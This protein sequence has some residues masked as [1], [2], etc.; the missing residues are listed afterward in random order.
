MIPDISVI[1]PVYNVERYLPDCLDSVLGQEGCTLEV[2]LIDDGSTDRSGLICDQYAAK[3]SRIKVIHQKNAGAAAAKNVGLR[4][5]TGEC[6]SFV[7]SDDFLEPGAYSY[8]LAQLCEYDADMIQCAFRN[9]FPNRSEDIIVLPEFTHFEA[10]EYLPR[11][12][13][14][15]TCGLL[16]DKLYRRAL[17]DGISFEEGHK[18]DDEFFTYRGIMNAE[19]ILHSPRV[20]Y[21]YRQRRSGIMRSSESSQKI[22]LDKVDYLSSRRKKVAARFPELKKIFDYHYLNMMVILSTDAAAT[23][24][25][26]RYSRKSLR[27]YFW[28]RNFC[29]VEF[30]LAIKLLRLM[31]LSPEKL[32]HGVRPAAEKQTEPYFD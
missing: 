8:M 22:L 13:Q 5:A 11:Y 32:L 3:D 21:N 1:V 12:T 23:E 30:T 14:D 28:E 15:W 31:T 18:I 9:V 10:E 26:I 16:W 17:Y 27:E 6:L 24:S 4:I 20:V 25:S 7:D 19:R 2:I 29:R